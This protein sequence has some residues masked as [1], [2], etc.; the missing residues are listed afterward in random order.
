[1]VSTAFKW[2]YFSIRRYINQDNFWPEKSNECLLSLVH[3]T[4]NSNL[5]YLQEIYCG[6]LWPQ[7]A[8][9]FIH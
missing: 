3:E 2:M 9:S 7:E 5:F 8:E 1:M 4:V 6:Y